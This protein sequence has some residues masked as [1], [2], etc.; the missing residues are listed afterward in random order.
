MAIA[1]TF[2]LATALSADAFIV[3]ASVASL[4]RFKL[5]NSL[6]LATAFA[7]VQ[8]GLF[9][10]GFLLGDFGTKFALSVFPWLGF[11]LLSILGIK[12]IRDGLYHTQ[13]NKSLHFNSIIAI[14]LLAISVSIDALVAGIPYPIVSKDGSL[15]FIIVAGVTF[16]I[17]FIGAVLSSRLKDKCKL[18]VLAGL[19]LISIG[20]SLLF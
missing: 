18:S 6:I 13:C 12:A 9:S 8:G 11:I 4:G 7:L 17:T 16:I 20:I 14:L 10:F 2:L 1:Q 3:A 15:C 5:K 19:A